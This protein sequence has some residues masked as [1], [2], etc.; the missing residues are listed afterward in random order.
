MEDIFGDLLKIKTPPLDEYEA[1]EIAEAEC[2]KFQE[3]I[4]GLYQPELQSLI[5]AR[6]TKRTYA[7]VLRP[8]HKVL[9]LSGMEMPAR[10]EFVA[11]YYHCEILE[12][13]GP[14]RIRKLNAAIK[15]A[16][17]AIGHADPTTSDLVRAVVRAVCLPKSKKM[18]G[19][20]H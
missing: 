4:E 7:E 13:A 19:H 9:R 12:G 3:L 16:H 11:A 1:R 6:S 18:N 5:K 15:W 10:P 8:F 2:A 17:L 20:K 14:A